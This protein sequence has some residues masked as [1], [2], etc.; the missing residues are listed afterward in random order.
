MIQWGMLSAVMMFAQANAACVDQGFD[1]LPTVD[2]TV[3]FTPP[4]STIF[5]ALNPATHDLTELVAALVRQNT[6]CA[7]NDLY[8]AAIVTRDRIAAAFNDPNVANARVLI[9]LPDGTVVVDTSKSNDPCCDNGQCT[10]GGNNTVCSPTAPCPAE[11]QANG[12]CHFKTKAVNENHNS[13]IAILSAQLAPCGLG[14]ETKFSTSDGRAENY[15]AIRLGQLFNNE[16]TVRA[17][18]VYPTVSCPTEPCF[19]SRSGCVCTPTC[20]DQ[21]TKKK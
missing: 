8:C 12:F 13:R 16:G 21:V 10:G 7:Y 2:Q 19:T 1:C 18:Y 4:Y 11:P 17:S 3:H 6:P 14:Y 9:A 20:P 5:G 15:V